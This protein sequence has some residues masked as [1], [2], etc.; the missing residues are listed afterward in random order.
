MHTDEPSPDT[1]APLP[2]LKMYGRPVVTL[3]RGTLVEVKGSEEDTSAMSA[4]RYQGCPVCEEPAYVEVSVMAPGLPA[5]S[6]TPVVTTALYS[7]LLSTP[8]LQWPPNVS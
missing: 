1:P 5:V 7:V 2:P 4:S 8:V 6:D 3:T